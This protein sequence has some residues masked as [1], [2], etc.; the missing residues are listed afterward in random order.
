MNT[1]MNPYH[2]FLRIVYR[3]RT[4]QIKFFESKSA[5]DLRLAKSLEKQV[6]EWLK[7]CG[8]EASQIKQM[9]LDL[10]KPN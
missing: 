2:E 10:G 8:F 9:R 3:M 7:R 4:A 5:S 1:P 6:D